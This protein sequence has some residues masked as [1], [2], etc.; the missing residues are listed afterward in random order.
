MEEEK[1]NRKEEKN[2]KPG[3]LNVK[4]IAKE[5]AKTVPIYDTKYEDILSASHNV[6][7]NGR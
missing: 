4:E 5:E 7:L 3:D 2:T 1:T 6:W